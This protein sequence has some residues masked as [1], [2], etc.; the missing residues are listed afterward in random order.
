[1]TKYTCT[2]CNFETELRSNYT[3]H[4][5]TN[6]H[7]HNLIKQTQEN[8][9][10]NQTLIFPSKTLNCEF[11]NPQNSSIFPQKPSISP[12]NSSIEYKKFCCKY[13]GRKYSRKDN[14]KRHLDNGC[15]EKNDEIAELK[16][17]IDILL[18][19]ETVSSNT[20][21][22]NTNSH[23]TTNSNNVQNN[24][25]NLNIFGK[26]DLSMLTDDFKQELIKGP[27]KMMP[28]LMEMI[29]FNKQYPENHTIK[30]VN[31][32]KELMKIHD[33]E[34]WKLADKEE[35]VDYIL[36]D[37]NYELDSYYDNNEDEFSLFVKNTYKKFRKLFDSRDR[38]LWKKLKRDVDILLWNNM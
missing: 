38:K 23:N 24:T 3:R 22:N 15:K 17:K 1:M 11:L 25:I 32:N 10:E 31:K 37:K 6:K 26:E 8:A 35:T 5:R 29:Y 16:E 2:I 4:L 21:S 12:Q 30:M 19:K 20:N 9:K 18:N 27:F 14:L 34:G 28:K 13:C 7:K 33:K 36:E